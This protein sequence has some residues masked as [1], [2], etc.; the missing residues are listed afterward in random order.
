MV[1]PG[2]K[3]PHC[4]TANF[5]SEMADQFNVAGIGSHDGNSSRVV[6]IVGRNQLDISEEVFVEIAPGAMQPQTQVDA[7]SITRLVFANITMTLESA[8]MLVT[9]LEQGIAQAETP[10]Q[11]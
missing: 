3:I 10:S 6:L 7:V 8:K 5:I 2:A 4:K 11:E 1:G 9:T